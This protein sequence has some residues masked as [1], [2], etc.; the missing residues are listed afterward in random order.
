MSAFRIRSRTF[1]LMLGALLLSTA[2]AFAEQLDLSSVSSTG[3]PEPIR[4]GFYAETAL[5][6]FLT[7]GGADSYSNMEA[8]L[9]LGV[10]YDIMREFSV[11]LQFQLAPSAGDCYGPTDSYC[12]GASAQGSGTFTMAAIDAIVTYRLPITERLFIPF[13][14]F[15]GMANL[16][17]LPR[18]DLGAPSGAGDIW[19][20]TV[21]LAS[22]IEYATRFDHFTVGIEASGRFVPAL[23]MIALAFYPRIRYTF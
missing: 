2:P 12:A 21:G 18:S 3:S 19:V 6:S 16:S 8:F 20:P 9:S 4:T 7:L 22:G 1:G 15:G 17:P 11:G 10:G 5:G 23:N 13:R 14:L